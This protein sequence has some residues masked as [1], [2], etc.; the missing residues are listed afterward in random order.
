[1]H[2]KKFL[3]LYLQR[4]DLK[5]IAVQAG[6]HPNT[7]YSWIK[8]RNNPHIMSLIWFFRALSYKKNVEYELLWIEFLYLLE[9][10]DEPK[11]KAHSW[12]QSHLDKMVKQNPSWLKKHFEHFVLEIEDA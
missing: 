10:E 11:A 1:M 2:I 6:I 9:G 3:S 8:N 4:G 5:S 12:L 7:V